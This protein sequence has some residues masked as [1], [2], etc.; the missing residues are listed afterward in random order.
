MNL[1]VDPDLIEQD[2]V[3]QGP[4][5]FPRKHWLEINRLLCVVV[6][7]HAEPVRANDI[8]CFHPN[9]EMLHRHL[10]LERIDGQGPLP[11]LQPAPIG[12]QLGLV[13][14]GPGLDQTLLT[15]RQGTRD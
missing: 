7:Q 5:K 1:R 9:D 6:K 12:K 15:P 10:L 13:K 11:R 2:Q 8:E 4:V 3:P 14:F